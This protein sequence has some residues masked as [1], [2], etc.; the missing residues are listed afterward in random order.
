LQ[1]SNLTDL[2]T[3]GHPANIIST[4]T[5]NF[6]NNLSNSDNTVQE[7]LE[8]ID[9]FDISSIWHRTAHNLPGENISPID[10]V[11]I[12]SMENNTPGQLTILQVKHTDDTSNYSG[13]VFEVKGDGPNYTNNMYFGKYSDNF[14]VPSWAGRGVVATDQDMIIGALGNNSEIQFQITGGYTT[15]YNI[16]NLNSNGL[17][18]NNS[19]VRIDRF[20]DEDD[21]AS[22]SDVALATQQSIK[23]YVDGLVGGGGY[24]SRNSANGYLY[25]NTLTDNVGIGTVSPD[26]KLDILISD[27]DNVRGLRITNND[28]T[29]NPNSLRID[30]NTSGVGLYINQQ[31]STGTGAGLYINNNNN[32]DAAISISSSFG[33]GATRPLFRATLSNVL[34]DQDGFV[35]SDRGV[36]D[37]F[38]V[39]K[40]NTGTAFKIQHDDDGDADTM[41]VARVGDNANNIVA[42]RVSAS[43]AGTGNAYA[44]LFLGGN[45]GV[46]TSTPQAKLEVVGGIKMGDD[47]DSCDSNKVGTMRYRSN[48]NNSYVDMCVQDG[49]SSYIW[50]T[51]NQE[52][53]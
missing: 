45:V 6:N 26:E 52:T 24:W 30:N 37:T 4:D 35:F 53:W 40:D 51:I 15:P 11:N 32:S 36:G 20:L 34:N 5:T 38:F 19:G 3:S 14:W 21:F 50:K 43:N 25:P 39:D 42:M 22:D 17:A 46:G 23:A 49:A 10:D 8:T 41:N 2:T 28:T 29:N 31:A 7:A 13:A 44:G 12:I 9:D 47:S 1:H 33:A 27:T 48:A 16:L 18:F